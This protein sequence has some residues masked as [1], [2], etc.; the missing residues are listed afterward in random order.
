MC[1]HVDIPGVCPANAFL[2]ELKKL[3]LHTNTGQSGWVVL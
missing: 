2:D 1:G 3:T